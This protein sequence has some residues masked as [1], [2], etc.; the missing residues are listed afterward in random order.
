[1][2]ENE[3]VNNPNDNENR[4]PSLD[5]LLTNPKHSAVLSRRDHSPSDHDCSRHKTNCVGRTDCIRLGLDRIEGCSDN[6]VRLS[7]SD[8]QQVAIWVIEARDSLQTREDWMSAACWSDTFPSTSSPLVLFLLKENRFFSQVSDGSEDVF[9]SWTRPKIDCYI[10]DCARG[11]SRLDGMYLN[12]L[13]HPKGFSPV[14]VY[15][16]VLSALG[17]ANTLQ[18]CSHSYCFLFIFFPPSLLISPIDT[19]SLKV[20]LLEALLKD[21][22]GEQ[23]LFKKL[24]SKWLC[25]NWLCIFPKKR[26]EKRER[27]RK[28]EKKR[29]KKKMIVSI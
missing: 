29:G 26:G 9:A 3:E 12:Y 22:R 19:W 7:A 21:V 8:G 5:L 28:R 24:M 25:C 23:D 1:M 10:L 20:L 4:F 2:G 11:V 17:L 13:E 14:C 6:L 27:E 15:L 18:Q 16:C